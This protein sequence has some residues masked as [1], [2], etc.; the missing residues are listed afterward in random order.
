MGLNYA[1][2]A[3][4]SSVGFDSLLPSSIGVN[5]SHLSECLHLLRSTEL[6][7]LT[8]LRRVEVICLILTL[9]LI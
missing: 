7:W 9:E 2:N 3:L 6:L 1:M 4:L 8:L 5:A